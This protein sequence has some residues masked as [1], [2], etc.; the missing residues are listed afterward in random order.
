[1]YTAFPCSEYHAPSD[2]SR[3]APASSLLRLSAGSPCLEGARDLPRSHVSLWCC[4]TLSDPGGATLVMP[5]SDQRDVAAF[6]CFD[7][8]SHPNIVHYGAQSLHPCG[9]RLGTSPD[10]A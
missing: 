1:M 10:Y 2:F 3:V 8:G 4:A 7:A 6:G 5:F 9:L